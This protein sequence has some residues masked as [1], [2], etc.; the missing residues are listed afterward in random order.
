VIKLGEDIEVMPV[1]AIFLCTLVAMVGTSLMTS[2]PSDKTL[3][4]FFPK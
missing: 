2:P 3:A 1:V 4:K